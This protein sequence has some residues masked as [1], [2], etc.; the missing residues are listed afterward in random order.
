MANDFMVDNRCPKC[1]STLRGL[2]SELDVTHERTPPPEKT[3]CTRCFTK[4]T[5][6]YDEDDLGPCYYYDYAALVV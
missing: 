4:L 2:R 3:T 1:N 5:R 6:M